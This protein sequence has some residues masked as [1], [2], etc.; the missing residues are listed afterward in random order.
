LPPRLAGE[1]ARE[2]QR[3][4]M[5]QEQIAEIEREGDLPWHLMSKRHA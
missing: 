1:I 2:I 3:L 5:V 4:A